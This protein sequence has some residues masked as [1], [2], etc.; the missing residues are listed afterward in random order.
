MEMTNEEI[1][2]SYRQA[3]DPR[4]QITILAELNLCSRS[5]IIEILIDGGVDPSELP[6]LP[7]YKGSNPYSPLQKTQLDQVKA[8]SKG[9]HWV[10]DPLKNK[11]AAEAVAKAK[12]QYKHLKQAYGEDDQY[13]V[14]FKACIDFLEGKR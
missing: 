5:R 6:A 10:W 3:L 1:V 11:T 2:R 8:K 9:W 7:K 14:G 13:V 12:A 4:K